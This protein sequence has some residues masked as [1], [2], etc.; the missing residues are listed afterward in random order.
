MLIRLSRML[1]EDSSWVMAYIIDFEKGCLFWL[2]TTIIKLKAMTLV[3]IHVTPRPRV[4]C[5][6]VNF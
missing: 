1:T 3:Y 2:K 4:I 6:K 5:D